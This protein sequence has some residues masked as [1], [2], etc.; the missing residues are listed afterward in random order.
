MLQREEVLRTSPE[1]VRRMAAA[2]EWLDVAEEIQHEVVKEFGLPGEAGLALLRSATHRF[3]ELRMLAVYA[4][5][6]L[7]RDGDLAEG[8]VC[9]DVKLLQNGAS[10]TSWE[11]HSQLVSLHGLAAKAAGATVLC[12]GSYS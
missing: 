5:N 1:G 4:R 2:R 11:E 6:N 8:D 7:A 9:P 12:A 3:P 10:G